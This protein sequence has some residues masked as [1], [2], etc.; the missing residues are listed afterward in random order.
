VNLFR[1]FLAAT[2][3]E[4]A[5]LGGP[6]PKVL[7]LPLGFGLALAAAGAVAIWAVGRHADDAHHV[8]L[9]DSVG[10]TSVVSAISS[11]VASVE[12]NRKAIE[13]VQQALADLRTAPRAEG[14]PS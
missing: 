3:T 10:K 6:Q 1:Q 8:P 7:P 13:D 9:P 11:L 5:A 4:A 14:A 2:L 12:A